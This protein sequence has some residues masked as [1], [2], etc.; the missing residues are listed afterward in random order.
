MRIK[1][2]REKLDL[3]AKGGTEIPPDP[4]LEKH[5]WLAAISD[6]FEQVIGCV[7][8]LIESGEVKVERSTIDIF[9]EELGRYTVPTLRLEINKQTFVFVPRSRKALGADGRV[10]LFEVGDHGHDVMLLYHQHDGDEHHCW[11]IVDRD[12]WRGGVKL[13]CAVLDDLLARWVKVGSP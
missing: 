5:S 4:D 8:D 7:A 12:D 10:D 2:L 11:E 6:L 3:I 13:S 9:E 1:T